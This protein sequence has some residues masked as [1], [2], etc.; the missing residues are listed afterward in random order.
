MRERDERK[1]ETKRERR[2]ERHGRIDKGVEATLSTVLPPPRDTLRREIAGWRLKVKVEL[3]P[4]RA[5]LESFGLC[6][7][8]S[9]GKT[10]EGRR[11]ARSVERN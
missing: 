7:E 11:G 10:A 9:R 1:R 5:N 4:A 6:I 2:R 8:K 3:F